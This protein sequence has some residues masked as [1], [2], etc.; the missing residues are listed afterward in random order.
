MS[1][2]DWS[3]TFHAASRAVDMAA[4]TDE[5]RA[6]VEC[7]EMVYP[8]IRYPGNEIRVAGRLALAVDPV[9]KRV[10]TVLWHRAEG[11]D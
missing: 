5:I 10:L 2:E 3:F 6:A 9:A 4:G 11:R 7:P 1:L 8:Q